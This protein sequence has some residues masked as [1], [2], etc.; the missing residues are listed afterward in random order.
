MLCSTSFLMTWLISSH[1][2]PSNL[3]SVQISVCFS[4]CELSAVNPGLSGGSESWDL[5][6][7][8]VSV[9]RV[10]PSISSSPVL[11][12][13]HSYRSHEPISLK[14]KVTS[15]TES[16]EFLSITFWSWGS[17]LHILRVWSL[18]HVTSWQS[19]EPEVQNEQWKTIIR[20][21]S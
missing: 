21:C 11:L 9:V 1:K 6:V 8:S 2:N 13:Q 16:I 18:D 12:A 17:T 5:R 4:P 10:K 7:F 19:L 14:H 15:C 20:V 3:L